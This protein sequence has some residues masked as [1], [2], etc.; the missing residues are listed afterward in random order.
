MALGLS[1]IFGVVRV[2]NS[3][4]ANSRWWPCTPPSA[5]DAYGLDPLVTMLPVAAL[6]FVIGY[7]LQTT[8]CTVSSRGGYQQFILLVGL[9]IMIVTGC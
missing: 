7:V 3:P 5:V 4:M 9:A 8:S 1:V 6:F 2:V